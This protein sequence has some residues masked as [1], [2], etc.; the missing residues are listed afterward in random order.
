MSKGRLYV[1]DYEQGAIYAPNSYKQRKRKK[2]KGKINS[3]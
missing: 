1:H 2:K 3:N